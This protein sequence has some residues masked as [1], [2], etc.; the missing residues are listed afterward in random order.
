MYYQFLLLNSL[1]KVD[2]QELEL[3]IKL[4]FRIFGV[5]NIILWII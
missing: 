2:L 4:I 5:L 1:K 3:L